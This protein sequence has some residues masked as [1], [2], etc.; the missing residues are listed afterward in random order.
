MLDILAGMVVS[1][2]SMVGAAVL[3]RWAVLA[4]FRPTSVKTTIIIDSEDLSADEIEY[5]VR[6]LCTRLKWTQRHKDSEFL[7]KDS[8][9]DPECREICHRLCKDYGFIKIIK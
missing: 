9:M 5:T 2:L 3:I 4:I 7:I 1:V 6:C 8:G